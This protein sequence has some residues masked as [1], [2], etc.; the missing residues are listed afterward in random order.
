M[1]EPD[2]MLL[3]MTTYGC[4]NQMVKELIRVCNT[5]TSSTS[6]VRFKYPEVCYNHHQYRDSVDNHNG[7]KIFPTAIEGQ[8]KTTRWP[9]Q[10]F[11]ILIAVTEVNCNLFNDY[12]FDKELQEQIESR[13]QLGSEMMNKPYINISDTPTKRRKIMEAPSKHELIFLSPSITFG[14]T[15][16]Q[17]CKTQPR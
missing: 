10:V 11:Q 1:K 8:C 7:R 16:I 14:T 6:K 15:D 17:R 3:F 5:G 9:N 4:E 2:N 12:Y 13:Y